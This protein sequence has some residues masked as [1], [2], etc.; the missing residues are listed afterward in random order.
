M[1]QSLLFLV[2]KWQ[3]TAPTCKTFSCQQEFPERSNDMIHYSLS[4]G[5]SLCLV[6]QKYHKFL[7]E[8]GEFDEGHVSKG[9]TVAK[10]IGEFPAPLQLCWQFLAT[11]LPGSTHLNTQCF[12]WVFG[13][14]TPSRS[15]FRLGWDGIGILNPIP[16][17]GLDSYYL[18]SL[19][20]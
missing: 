16:R 10:S 2:I 9:K 15:E 6:G 1:K 7:E 11:F 20:L 18:I 12:T 19:S 3:Q 4:T 5:L 14:Y 17:M 13:G 8:A